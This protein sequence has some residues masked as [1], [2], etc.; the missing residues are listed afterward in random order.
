METKNLAIR[1]NVNFAVF[2]EDGGMLHVTEWPGGWQP[3]V[4]DV[5]P[6]YVK[7]V[8]GKGR[9]DY[10]TTL[11]PQWPDG[12]RKT[13]VYST[14]WVGRKSAPDTYEKETVEFVFRAGAGVWMKVMNGAE[15]PFSA[16]EPMSRHTNENDWGRGQAANHL[17]GRIR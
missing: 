14:T 8:D 11:P 3:R 12:L 1:S 17:F 10:G 9:V 16:E 15:Y 13:C 6:V 4:G 7:N 2:M 5:V